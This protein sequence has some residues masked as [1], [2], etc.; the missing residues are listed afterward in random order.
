MVD[1]AILGFATGAGF[2]LVENLYYLWTLSE[3]NLLLWG[4]RGFGT[5]VLHGST[6]AIAGI[7]SKLLSDVRPKGGPEI[8]LPGLGIAVVAHALFNLSQLYLSPLVFTA[9]L[10]AAFPLLVFE[11]F[12]RSERMLRGWLDVGFGSDVELLDMLRSGEVRDTRVGQY[13]R[14]LRDRFPGEVIADMLCYL[15]IMVELSIK[16][17]GRLLMKEAGFPPPPDPVIAARLEELAFL[18]KSIGVTGKLA[19]SPFVSKTS[20]DLWQLEMLKEHA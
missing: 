4:I 7:V 16:A 11:V 20:R 19:L 12:S 3:P 9:V 1:A 6:T 15:E 13:L 17:K 18:E 10:V 5:A 8:F 14:S 2:A